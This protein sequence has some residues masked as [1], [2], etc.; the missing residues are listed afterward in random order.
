MSY[1]GINCCHRFLF[2]P[3]KSFISPN[4]EGWFLS[5]IKSSCYFFPKVF[6]FALTLWV[7]MS[8]EIVG[9]QLLDL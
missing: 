3:N 9:G 5:R 2:E 1:L 4:L 6:I 7:G 8:P